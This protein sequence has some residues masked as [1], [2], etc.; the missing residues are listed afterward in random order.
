MDS[1]GDLILIPAG[2]ME[3]G[4]SS[5]AGVPIMPSYGGAPPAIDATMWSG[6]RG[7]LTSRRHM[8]RK[9]HWC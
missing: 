4:L 7:L 2:G 8:S 1:N 3:F 6:A 9:A 5:G